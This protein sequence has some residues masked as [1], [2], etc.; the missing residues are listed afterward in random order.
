MKVQRI[1]IG[2]GLV[3][4]V[5]VCVGVYA[6]SHRL[7]PITSYGDVNLNDTKADVQYELGVP[8][9]V[10][11][12]DAQITPGVKGPMTYQVESPGEF[13]VIPEG[14]DWRDAEQWSYRGDL[15]DLFAPETDIYF[16]NG[17]V[18]RIECS[19]ADSDDPTEKNCPT[20]YGFA[21]SGTTE[22][23]I[24]SKLGE[25]DIVKTTDG[26]RLIVYKRLHVSFD[27][28]QMEVSTTYVGQP[29]SPSDWVQEH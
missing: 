13:P 2:L 10:T 24:R 1:G 21:T 11:M 25:P 16:Q 28:F 18:L 3:A 20:V 23:Q 17:K 9:Y 6:L 26:W 7:P 8:T 22:D 14:S 5:G 12:E 19:Q 15:D 4:I 27:L 29:P